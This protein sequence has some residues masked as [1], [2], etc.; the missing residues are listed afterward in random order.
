VGRLDLLCQDA[1]G[2][3]V[4]VELKKTK[5]TDQVVGQLL[6]YIGWARTEYAKAKVRRTII[7]GQKG[8]ALQWPSKAVP[9]IEIKEFKL[10]IT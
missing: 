4:V 6:G 1:F 3:Y 9:D 8:N 2:N 5:G 7:V 10:S